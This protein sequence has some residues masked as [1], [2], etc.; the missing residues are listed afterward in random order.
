LCLAAHA[1]ACIPPEVSLASQDASA[2]AGPA[3]DPADIACDDMR[4]S[5]ECDDCCTANHM[6]G[7]RIYEGP[8][9]QCVCSMQNCGSQC[10][11]T[12]CNPSS[13]YDSTTG[14]PCSN[15][16]DQVLGTGGACA[17]ALDS[18]CDESA[19]CRAYALCLNN[20]P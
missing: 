2:D 10:E 16:E 8:F 5:T 11:Q 7:E 13:N 19:D 9:M 1:A 18:V 15:C 20:C 3:L 12:D 4:T 6:N 17:D 14:D